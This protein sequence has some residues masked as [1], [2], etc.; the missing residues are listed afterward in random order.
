MYIY[1]YIY[2]YTS[3]IHNYMHKE[4]PHICLLLI[5]GCSVSNCIYL[6]IY[7]TSLSP[8]N[9]LHVLRL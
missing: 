4:S 7:K 1:I 3:R 8:R 9:D 5:W 2:I 6:D